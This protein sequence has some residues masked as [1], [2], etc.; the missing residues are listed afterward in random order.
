[1]NAVWPVYVMGTDPWFWSALCRPDYTTASKVKLAEL[2]PARG[3]GDLCLAVPFGARDRADRITRHVAG[4]GPQRDF[5]FIMQS[6]ETK[7]E[8]RISAKEAERQEAI[9]KL[10]QWLK[11]ETTV[12]TVLRSVSASGMSRTLDLYVVV[13]GDILRIT[14]SVAK[15]LDATYDRKKE[16]LKV[17]GYGMDMGWDTVYHLSYAVLGDGYALKHRWL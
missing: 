15:A 6:N 7:P 9:A 17:M 14:W 16:A 13:E 2:A 10:R 1:M 5:A 3:A 8:R 4:T 12:Y 11:P